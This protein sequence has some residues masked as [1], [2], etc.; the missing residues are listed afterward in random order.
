M[1]QYVYIMSWINTS[2]LLW[3][4]DYQVFLTVVSSIYIPFD[5]FFITQYS[6]IHRNRKYHDTGGAVP[7]FL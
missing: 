4:R 5:P 3:S 6:N 7:I 2:R 1:N